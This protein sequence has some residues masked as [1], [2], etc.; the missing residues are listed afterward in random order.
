MNRIIG[1]HIVEARE[2]LYWNQGKELVS[3]TANPRRYNTTLRST[4]E[5]YI[6]SYCRVVEVLPTT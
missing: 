3:I 5:C 2:F 1:M 4:V 6:D